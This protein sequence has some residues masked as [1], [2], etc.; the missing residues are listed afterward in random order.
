MTLSNEE[1]SSHLISSHTPKYVQFMTDMCNRR[2]L[3]N[4][5]ITFVPIMV[6][7]LMLMLTYR[8]SNDNTITHHNDSEVVT[9]TNN[10]YDLSYHVTYLNSYIDISSFIKKQP[11]DYNITLNSG[12]MKCCTSILIWYERHYQIKKSHLIS[13]HLIH[14]NTCN[15]WQICAIAENHQI[16]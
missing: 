8:Y 5:I 7:M 4:R 9:Y 1:I 2:D 3:L 12:Q 15:S 10:H 11:H 16:E 13:S 6:L 14:P